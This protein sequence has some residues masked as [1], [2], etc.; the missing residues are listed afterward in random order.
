[1]KEKK[2]IK[3]S[4]NIKREDIFNKHPCSFCC[5]LIGLFSFTLAFLVSEHTPSYLNVLSLTIGVYS[6]IAL[7]LFYAEYKWYKKDMSKTVTVEEFGGVMITESVKGGKNFIVILLLCNIGFWIYVS[8]AVI[9]GLGRFNELLMVL[10]IWIIVGPFTFY[11][12]RKFLKGTSELRKFIINEKFIQ[13]IVP[14][15]PLFHVNW[16]EIDKIELTLQPYMKY[17]DIRMANSTIPTR[18]YIFIN[19]L[20]FIGKNYNQTYQILGGRDFN[21][22]LTEIFNLVEKYA[23]K[24]NKEF[25]KS[26]KK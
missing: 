5:L 3:K 26:D 7:L 23:I 10:I 11:V 4:I 1:L 25:I 6:S 17:P 16:I 24:L 2:L 9:I 18:K 19:E 13:I 15:R 21:I 20:K 22:K 14:P 12:Y 8:I